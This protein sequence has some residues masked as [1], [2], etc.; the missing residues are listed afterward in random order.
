M[1]ATML[2]II[3]ISGNRGIFILK[4]GVVVYTVSRLTI[5]RMVILWS[6]HWLIHFF[7]KQTVKQTTELLCP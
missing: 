7:A 3:F 2:H 6:L 1:M 5:D 4:V